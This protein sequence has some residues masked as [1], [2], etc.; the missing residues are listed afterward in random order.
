M[1]Q[2]PLPPPYMLIYAHLLKPVYVHILNIHTCIISMHAHWNVCMHG[3]ASKIYTCILG[4]GCRDWGVGF[5]SCGIYT[6]VHAHTCGIYTCIHAHTGWL[7]PDPSYAPDRVDFT[8]HCLAEWAQGRCPCPAAGGRFSRR[9]KNGTGRP[10]LSSLA[11]SPLSL[12]FS[13]ERYGAP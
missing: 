5:C 11:L 10:S 4:S 9:Q 6:H 1:C 7:T 13:K 12:F 2:I 3:Q 8:L